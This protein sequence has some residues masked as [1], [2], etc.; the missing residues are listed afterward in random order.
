MATLLVKNALVVTMDEQRREIAD[1]GLYAVDGVIR[2]VG[3][4]A[5]LPGTADTVMDLAGHIVLPG[6]ING[7]H[8]LDQTLTRALPAAQNNNLFRWL[9]A[10]YR[11]WAARTPEASRTATLVGCAELALSGCTTV[12]DHAYVFRNGCTVDDQIAAAREIGIRFAVSRGSMSLG[13]SKGGLPP[14]SCVEDEDEILKDCERVIG[15]YHDAAPGS[16]T[17]I[18]LAPCSPFFRD[19]RIAAPVGSD[20]T[21]SRSPPAYASLRDARRGAL[22]RAALGHAARRI[23][24]L[25][26]LGGRRCLVRP[27]HPCERRPRS[28]SSRAPASAPATAPARTCGW[29]PA[30]RR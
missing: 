29:P 9:Q 15:R 8:H 12:F 7:H 20:G 26:R 30:S 10:H 13:Q 1:G 3:P 4:G 16:M 2:S 21:A 23:H 24:A 28:G 18:V 6:L 22:H 11:L 17:Q 14:D 25:R 5:S 27:R 19:T